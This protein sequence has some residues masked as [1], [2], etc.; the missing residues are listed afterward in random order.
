MRFQELVT[1]PKTAVFCL[2]NRKKNKAFLTLGKD[3]LKRLTQIVTE[4]KDGSFRIKEMNSDINDLEIIIL[5][6][7][8]DD[9]AYQL[10]R[11]QMDYWYDYISN[12]GIGL[13]GRR[14]TFL[15]YRPRLN[16]GI[17]FSGRNVIFVELVNKRYEAE[18]V[19]VFDS[20]EEAENFKQ[21]YFLDQKYVYPIYSTNNLSKEY[22][23]EKQ[24]QLDSLFRVR[25]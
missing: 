21:H 19:G 7:C 5:E 17:D 20:L 14:H 16:M 6:T 9:S 24:Q 12:L 23:L 13:Y 15:K 22:F 25:V 8:N 11:M 18:V 4:L 3:Y 1:A 2:Y 10:F